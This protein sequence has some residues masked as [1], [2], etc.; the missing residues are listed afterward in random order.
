MRL[1]RTMM[2]LM[3]ALSVAMLPA[4]VRATPVVQSTPQATTEATAKDTVMA[5][6]MSGA[7]D[8]C[9][10]HHA[11][12][13]PKPCDQPNGQCPMAF[14]AIQAVSLAVAAAF[15]FDSPMGAGHPLP[16]PEDQVLALHSS[17]PPFRPPRV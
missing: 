3:I 13:K 11:K 17:S 1:V 7:M 15:H 4:A 5:S 6:D 16:I 14:C 12:A 10:P 9:C 2:A 8:E